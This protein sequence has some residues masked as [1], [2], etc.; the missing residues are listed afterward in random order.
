LLPVVDSP[1]VPSMLHVDASSSLAIAQMGWPHL[2]PPTGAPNGPRSAAA[3]AVWGE[4]WGAVRQASARALHC[5]EARQAPARARS[6]EQAGARCGSQ[7]HRRG[8]HGCQA[9]PSQGRSAA[10]TL[11]ALGEA[12]DR[13][14]PSRARGHQAGTRRPAR[15]PGARRPARP[16][17]T[18][19]GL[20]RARRGCAG[21]AGRRRANPATA[22]TR[23]GSARLPPRA[24]GARLGLRQ[25]RSSPSMAGAGW[26]WRRT[27]LA[28]AGSLAPGGGWEP[29]ASWRRPGNL[30]VTAGGYRGG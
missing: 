2:P 11:A 7:R 10:A 15:P 30:L 19:R 20:L 8:G 18:R 26:P 24:G 3:S 13:R 16:G 17:G 29:L 27:A 4:G 12:L 25:G 5:A 22:R 9:A 14:L 21:T 28:T 1:R 6:A 23:R